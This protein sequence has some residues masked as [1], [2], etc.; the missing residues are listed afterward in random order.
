MYVRLA[1]W[2]QH[3]ISL[4]GKGPR[5]TRY[6]HTAALRLIMQH[7]DEDDLFLFRFSVC[8]S[9]DRMELTEENRSMRGKHVPAPL[10]IPRG[11]VWDRTRASAVIDLRLTL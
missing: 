6:G 1:S 7:C 9:T 2:L 4:R 3:T 8:W 5:S 10:Q 11:L